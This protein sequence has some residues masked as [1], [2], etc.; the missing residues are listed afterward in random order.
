MIEISTSILN[1]KEENSLKM[2][3]NIEAGKTDYFHIDVMDGKFVKNDT[4]KR[5]IEYASNIKNICNTPLDVHLMVKEVKKYIDEYIDLDP[6]YITIHKESF[7]TKEEMNDIIKYIKEQGIKVGVSIK[8]NTPIDEIYNIL[9]QVHLVLVMTVE[10]G[11][12]GQS[13]ILETMDKIKK[14][15]EYRLNNNL[16][17]YIEADGGIN[18]NNIDVLKEAGIDIAV[19]GSAIVN[20]ENIKETIKLLKK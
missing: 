13:L 10:P 17:F 20:S 7:N 6:S 11:Y 8:P 1:V 16:D 9:D 3:Y 12:G 19:C 5:M 14:L 18:T 4:S 2:F 15:N